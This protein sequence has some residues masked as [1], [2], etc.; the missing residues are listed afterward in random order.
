MATAKLIYDAPEKN[1]DLYYATRFKAPDSFIYFEIRGRKYLV[2]NDLEIDRAKKQA[3]VD[4]VLSLTELIK[5]IKAKQK[6]YTGADLIAMLLKPR[7][8]HTV[9][10][11]SNTSFRLVDGLRDHGFS[12][13]SGGSPFYPKRLIKTA[14]ELKA[15]TASQRAVF[16]AMRLAETTLRASAI[17]GRR[18]TFR[19]ATL[20]SE[21]LRMMI[22]MYLMERGFVAQDTIVSC[23]NHS[24]DPHDVGSGPLRPNTSIII[25]VFPRSTKTM[26]FGDATRTFCRGRA[27]HALK[28]LYATVKK[29]Q[30][31]AIEAIK[32][33]KNGKTIHA[34]II[35]F[36]EREGYPTGR[37][38][39]RMQGFFHSTGHGV[40]LEIHEEPTRIGP[41]D[42]TLRT[43]NVVSVEPGL[44]FRGLG[45][46]RIEDLVAVTKTG[47]TVIA[48]YPKRFEIR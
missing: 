14:E 21:R 13:K 33:R 40:G 41:V 32:A 38:E 39:G 23:G 8:V 35:D 20:T 10:V 4:K 19:G 18:L 25:D 48:G 11:P 12:V 17:R 28:K 44:Y 46:V 27:P 29:G 3:T 1:V 36:F 42:C 47:C 45:G 43:G 37:L 34:S 9:I 2:M 6:R 30:T 16:G 5:G 31:N 15:I 22:G 7:N 26:Y 24:I